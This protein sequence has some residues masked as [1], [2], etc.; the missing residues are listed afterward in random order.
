[1]GASIP[2][3]ET[4]TLAPP[5]SRNAK[6]R[7]PNPKVTASR[8]KKRATG[9]SEANPNDVNVRNRGESQSQSMV[10]KFPAKALVM[11]QVKILKRGEPLGVL[12]ENREPKAKSDEDPDLLLGSIHRMEPASEMFQKQMRV[13]QINRVVDRVF[14]GTACVAS[15]PP[16][17]LPVPVFLGKGIRSGY[18]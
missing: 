5:S 15:P 12:A 3:C 16:S 10:V 13:R 7:N 4:Q 6:L 17:S 14:A 8:R 2:D 9:G 1:M 11:G 18:K